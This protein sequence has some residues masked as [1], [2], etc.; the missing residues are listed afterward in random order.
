MTALDTTTYLTGE[1]A[2]E[3]LAEC[4]AIALEH[5]QADDVDRRAALTA[6]L[7]AS[8]Q[9]VGYAMHAVHLV[10]KELKATE[11]RP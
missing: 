6:A 1:R 10:R 11:A 4:A 3:R 2:I 5:H 9:A 8:R 7:D